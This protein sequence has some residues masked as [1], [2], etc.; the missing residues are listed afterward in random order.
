MNSPTAAIAVGVSLLLG[1]MSAS[2]QEPVAP[3]H[4]GFKLPTAGARQLILVVTPGWDDLAGTIRTF[5]RSG[6]ETQ[7]LEVHG[8]HEMTLGAAGL[9]WGTGLHMI[10]SGTRPAKR[11]GDERSPAGVF[12]LEFLYGYAPEEEAERFSMPY[13]SLDS[14]DECIDDPSSMYYNM[15]VDR[16]NVSRVDWKSSERMRFSGKYYEWGIVVS[17][18]MDPR[19]PGAGSCIFLHVW[20]GNDASTTGCTSLDREGLLDIMEW[21]SPSAHPVLVQLPQSEYE[22]RRAEWNLP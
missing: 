5:E 19:T 4:E 8:E 13:L 17:H 14:T 18:N 20:G 15:I 11:E 22:S 10:G 9:A 12:S 3:A 7:W 1:G 16:R 6:E 21:L 2:A